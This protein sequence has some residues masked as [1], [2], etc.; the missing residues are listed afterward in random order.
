MSTSVFEISPFLFQQIADAVSEGIVVLDRDGHLI[1]FNAGCESLLGRT[2]LDSPLERWPEEL[3]LF[4]MDGQTQLPANRLPIAQ[5]LKGDEPEAVNVRVRLPSGE[6]RA[7]RL[8]AAALQALP[9]VC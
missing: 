8:S 2:P 5:V 9:P 4:L 3:A 6:A 1:H 7:L